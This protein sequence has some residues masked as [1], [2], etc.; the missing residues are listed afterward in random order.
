MSRRHTLR[1]RVVVCAL[2]ASLALGI[3]GEG[4]AASWIVKTSRPG[5]QIFDESAGPQLLDLGEGHGTTFTF[6][7]GGP[8]KLAIFFNAECSV[9]SND[10]NTWLDI[11]VLVDGALVASPSDGDNALCTSD[12]DGLLNNWVTASSDQEAV[13]LTPGSHS[14]QIQGQLQT[15]APGDDWWVGDLS[16]IVLL[17]ELP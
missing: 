2:G 9:A 3:A 16:L 1:S 15:A 10:A 13:V 14:I 5:N 17:K 12:G 7:T 6:F 8:T 11:D 4:S